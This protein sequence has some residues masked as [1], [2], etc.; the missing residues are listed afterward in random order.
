M[1]A[2]R[3]FN[4]PPPVAVEVPAYRVFE[5]DGPPI[6]REVAR[7]DEKARIIRKETVRMEGGYMV[8][9][10]KGHSNWYPDKAALEAAGLGE[11]VPLIT[12][13]EGAETEVNKDMPVR[14]TRREI[15]KAPKE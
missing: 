4:A 15:E 9:F 1:T 5:Y 2:H 8:V 11:V 12:L 10:A 6:E 14:A 3:V 13:S 7:F